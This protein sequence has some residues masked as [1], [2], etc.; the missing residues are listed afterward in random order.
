MTPQFRPLV[1][2]GLRYVE[3]MESPTIV[4]THDHHGPSQRRNQGSALRPVRLALLFGV[5]CLLTT[6]LAFAQGSSD[7]SDRI[8]DAP[9]AEG[10]AVTQA[11]DTSHLLRHLDVWGWSVVFETDDPFERVSVALVAMTRVH[12]DEDFTRTVVGGGLTVQRPVASDR[13]DVTVLI[14][15]EGDPRDLTIAID[16]DTSGTEATLP[17]PLSDGTG[18]VGR[19][20]G[21]GHVVPTDPDGRLVLLEIYPDANDGVIATGDVAD[22]LAYLAI[23]I[24]VE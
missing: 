11:L 22:M 23:E 14:D 16:G 3:P 1:V 4:T 20:Y 6:G 15:G 24:A 12:L 8:G 2:R 5:A 19:P 9:L 13:A 7:R 17:A 10:T 18:L 21:P